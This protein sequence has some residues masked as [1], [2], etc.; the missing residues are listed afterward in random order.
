MLTYVAADINCPTCF[1]QVIET[2]TA[3]PGVHPV[4]PHVVDGRIAITHDL[5][6]SVLLTTIT[7]IGHTLDI[8]PNGD[9]TMGQAHATIHV[10]DAHSSE[11]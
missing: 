5:D 11:H 2:I 4:D 9:I 7:T 10:C 3:T 6:E 8:A 1:N